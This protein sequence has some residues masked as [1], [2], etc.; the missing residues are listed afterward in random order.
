MLP[1]TEFVPSVDVLVD[2]NKVSG[3]PV[4]VIALLDIEG[5]R[6]GLMATH[7]PIIGLEGKECLVISRSEA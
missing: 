7:S 5:N 3:E 1:Y 6:L 4:L 2:P